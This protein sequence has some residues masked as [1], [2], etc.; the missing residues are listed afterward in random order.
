MQ[1]E[2]AVDVKI[3]D[4]RNLHQNVYRVASI[5]YKPVQDIYIPTL[6]PSKGGIMKLVAIFISAPMCTKIARANARE[7]SYR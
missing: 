6:P 5:V 3:D 2:V 7:I 1:F 4:F